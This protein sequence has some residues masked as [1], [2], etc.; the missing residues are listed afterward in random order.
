MIIIRARSAGICRLTVLPQTFARRSG[1][2]GAGVVTGLGLRPGR[3]HVCAGGREPWTAP[4]TDRRVR[5]AWQRGATD[6]AGI[7][8]LHD[9]PTAFGPA[10][11]LVAITMPIGGVHEVAV[12]DDGWAR[13]AGLA[14]GVSQPYS[15]E[16]LHRRALSH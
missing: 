14:L 5:R 15:S 12:R 6:V 8:V 10:Y 9:P 4:R 11:V 7:G 13:R 1:D 16:Y 3:D 2:P